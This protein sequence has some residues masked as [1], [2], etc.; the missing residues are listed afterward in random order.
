MADSE[1]RTYSS[2]VE[3]DLFDALDRLKANEPTHPELIRKARQKKLRINPT[4]V[5]KE[6]KRARTLIGLDNC[7]YP[8]VREAITELTGPPKPGPSHTEIVDGL[9][10]ENKS[11]RM[12]VETAMSRV[13]AM[14]LRM[15]A[16]EKEA[17]RQIQLEKRR[18]AMGANVDTNEVA[19]TRLKNTARNTPDNVVS[20][21]PPKGK[22]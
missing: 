22:R 9:E 14:A 11:L 18:A 13:A 17:I 5:A 15:E 1:S 2:E 8:R 16:V 21:H 3:K 6:A 20:L 4:T 12:S 19:G 10:R 7:A